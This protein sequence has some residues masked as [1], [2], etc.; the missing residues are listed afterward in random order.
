MSPVAGSQGGWER[1]LFDWAKRSAE[2]AE[3]ATLSAR[4]VTLVTSILHPGEGEGLA[5]IYPLIRDVAARG[6]TMVD[7][8]RVTGIDGQRVLLEG[9]FGEARPPVEEVEA[10]VTLVDAVSVAGLA[11]ATRHAGLTA[12]TIGD[13]HL[14]RD[15][16]SAVSPRSPPRGWPGEL[17]LLRA[18][19]PSRARASI[20]EHT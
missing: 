20:L 3:Q 1:L 8:A 17:T 13:A 4:R 6:V 19:P 11:L 18:R 2:T 5:T 9:V 12:V 7:R 15:V 14:P 16:T 10:V